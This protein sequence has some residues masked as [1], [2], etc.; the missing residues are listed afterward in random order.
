MTN[1]SHLNVYNAYQKIVGNMHMILE[2][3][4]QNGRGVRVCVYD[5]LRA[6][7]RVA[8]R[9]RQVGHRR[10]PIE[11]NNNETLR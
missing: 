1:V 7:K 11:V 5:V 2:L 6:M 10:P 3:R 9:Q 4:L 8:W